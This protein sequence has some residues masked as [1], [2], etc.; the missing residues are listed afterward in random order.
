MKKIDDGILSNIEELNE[1]RVGVR[2]AIPPL[3]P[4]SFWRFLWSPHCQFA[5]KTFR[6]HFLFIVWSIWEGNDETDTGLNPLLLVAA[7]GFATF[8][9]NGVKAMPVSRRRHSSVRTLGFQPELR[10][11]HSSRQGLREIGL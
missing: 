7:L 4:S 10:M 6:K 1:I 9:C 2:V 3:S 8:C 11:F 5:Q